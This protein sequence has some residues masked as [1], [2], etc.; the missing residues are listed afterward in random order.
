MHPSGAFCF[1]ILLAHLSDVINGQAV[2]VP[3]NIEAQMRIL[4]VNSTAKMASQVFPVIFSFSNY[5]TLPSFG[6]GLNDLN[7][8][9]NMQTISFQTEPAN[10]TSKTVNIA[11]T[12]NNDTKI[13]KLSIS[14]I[15]VWEHTGIFQIS[16]TYTNVARF[17]PR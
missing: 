2:T 10:L 5:S 12:I 9:Q 16:K 7:F 4:Y 15:S 17:L 1:F 14:Y 13:V 8:N 11:V 3:S 6:F